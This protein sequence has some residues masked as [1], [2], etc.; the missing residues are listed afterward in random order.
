MSLL[1][2]TQPEQQVPLHHIQVPLEPLP[3]LLAVPPVALLQ[4]GV[5]GPGRVEDVV[6]PEVKGRI[7]YRRVIVV[8]KY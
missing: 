4:L 1:S 3:D 7:F 6:I 2:L 5:V 8:R